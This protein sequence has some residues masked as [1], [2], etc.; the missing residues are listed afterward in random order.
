MFVVIPDALTTV[1]LAR[2]VSSTPIWLAHGNP[3]AN[4][5]WGKDPGARLPG[6]ADV[7]VIGAGFTG[8]ACAYHWSKRAGGRMVVLEMDD[9]ASGASGRNEGLVVM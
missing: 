3:L 4:H 9:P 8:G 7:V 2:T 1:T 5:P 6:D